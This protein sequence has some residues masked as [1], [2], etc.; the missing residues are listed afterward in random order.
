MPKRH[1]RFAV[2]GA[3]MS[4]L[5][6]GIR[7][8]AAG[9][10]DFTIYEKGDA[11]GGTWRENRYPGLACDVPAHSYTYS[12]APNPEWT[13]YFA[14]GGEIRRYFERTT[15]RFGLREHIRTHSEIVSCRYVG[16]RWQLKTADGREDVADVVIAATGVL[17]HPRWPD[18][19]GIESFTGDCFHSAR[20]PDGIDLA[21]KRVGIVG[22]GSTGVQMVTALAGNVAGLVHF[23][24]TPQ[25]IVKAPNYRFTEEER[26]AWRAD[27]TLAAGLRNSGDYWASYLR[28]G[29]ALLD[30][31]GPEM[32][33]IEQLVTENLEGVRDPALR[34]K[35]RPNYRAMCKRLIYSPNYYEMVEDHAVGIE[36]GKIARV[37]PAGIVMADGRAI[38]LDV[39]VF[40]TGFRTDRFVRPLVLTGRGGIDV[41]T[42]WS[43]RPRA[44]YAISI[45]EFP[46][47]FMLN[48][49]TSPVGNFSL[50]EIAEKQWTYIDQLVDRLRD[51]SAQEIC[52]TQSALDAYDVRRIA[53][54]KTTVF[55]SGCDS[56]YLD[57]E[58][59]PQTW[60]WS[61]D[62]FDEV[63]ATPRIEDYQLV[64]RK[65]AA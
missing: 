62:H 23:Q 61:Q 27:A 40:A 55:A 46:N 37:C 32:A 34:E 16:G 41:E 8:K 25:W 31:D 50:I 13:S 29:R 12:F 39:I 51:G 14:D 24:R 42:V 26:A 5:L 4:G 36:T 52:A 9:D 18:L 2:I 48:G 33:E 49:P 43:V 47:F 63:M 22:S 21:D 7:L 35:L 54:A 30:V 10:H 58:G 53:A 15:D 19:A 28:F 60:P 59:V 56:W 17:H 44:Y 64:A 20:W 11:V 45:P 65:A 38:D 6:A 1:L 57:A 3:G